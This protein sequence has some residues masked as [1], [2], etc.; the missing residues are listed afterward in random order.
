MKR[1]NTVRTGQ[2]GLINGTGK[3]GGVEGPEGQG[4]GVGE[5]RVD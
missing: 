3:A 5:T 1:W 4:G 2:A